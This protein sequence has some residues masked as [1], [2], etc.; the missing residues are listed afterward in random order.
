MTDLSELR[1]SM[2]RLAAQLAE[3]AKSRATVPC[4]ACG[5]AQE[6][7]SALM[8]P[9]VYCPACLAHLRATSDVVTVNSAACA[10]FDLKELVDKLNDEF[11]RRPQGRFATYVLDRMLCADDLPP[12]PHGKG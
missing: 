3:L 11:A 12:V 10:P 9:S 6:V 5:G 7:A 2:D 4:P 8:A 1:A